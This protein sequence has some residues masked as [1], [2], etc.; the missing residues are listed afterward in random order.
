VIHD[1]Y[2]TTHHF[3]F[4]LEKYGTLK[5]WALPKGMP[6][7]IG[8]KRLAIQTP[9]HPLSYINFKGNIPSGEYGA[10]KVFI[11][12]NG[13]YNPIIWTPEK[14]EFILYGK[15]YNGKYI[16]IPFKNDYLMIRGKQ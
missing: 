5:S 4:R 9:N 10:G 14:I 6:I 13:Y 7:H 2:A 8:D 12:D 11:E 16:I 15:K 1:H 3:D